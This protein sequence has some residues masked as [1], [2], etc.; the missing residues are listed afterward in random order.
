MLKTKNYDVIIIGGGIAG[1]ESA[2]ALARG[3]KQVALVER[4]KLGGT[5]LRWGA[6][7]IK[8]ILDSFKNLN[9]YDLS[10]RESI[11]ERLILK[12]DED[13]AL[14]D[15]KIKK[16]LEDLEIDIYFGDGEFINSHA[17]KL[18]NI[19]LETEYFIIAT[20]TEA[21][22]IKE[23][24]IDRKSIISHKEAINLKDLPKDIVIL[25]GN[26]EGVEIAAA[27]GEMGVNVILVEK[28]ADILFDN[29]QD[30]IKGIEEQL[31]SKNVKIIKGLGAKAIE[32]TEDG[33]RVIL[34]NE[35]VLIG[36]KVLVTFKRKVNIPRGI[37]NT[38]IK[39]DGNK[40]IVNESLLTHEENVFAIG[41]INGILGMAHV[42][43]QQGL[44][45]AEYILN[46]K[47]IDID[48]EILPRAI[49]TLPEMAGVGKQEWEL[50]DESIPYKLG[51]A[52]FKDSWRG[53]SKGIE[54]GFVKVIL[55]EKDI[56]LGIW[57]V[58]ENVSEYIG[59][60]GNLIKEE[61]TSDDI[62]SNL[63]IHPSLSETILEAI[64]EG[65]NK[66]MKR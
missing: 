3:G 26:V 19:L 8:K 1:Y 11:K 14:L 59:L 57:M 53:W 24:P 56:I 40:I 21:D 7:P 23:I 33:V 46:G 64:L 47:S 39:F 41:D 62:M 34:D 35:Q 48:Y 51:I 10:S 16:D 50:K 45:V 37:E 4:D 18:D 13:L 31:I 44:Q 52:F 15:N 49:F 29:D 66:G 2:R 20:G 17:F 12:W 25:G 30:L 55:D 27:Y 5:A 43:I 65:K 60:L 54:E 61:A 42:G 38:K 9:N 32:L 6:L 28:E 63:I 58:G 36:E 22:S